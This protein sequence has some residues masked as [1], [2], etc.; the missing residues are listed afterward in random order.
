VPTHDAQRLARPDPL[1]CNIELGLR[2]VYHPIGFQL[3]LA[4]NA[5]DVI[6]AAAEC[7]AG[8]GPEFE[9][10]S[11]EFRVVVEAAG[12]VASRPSFR[13]QHQLLSIVSDAHNFAV[14]DLHSQLACIYVSQGTA[15]DH[16]LLRW[17]FLESIAY[18]LLAQR[19]AAPL[20]AASVARNEIGVLLGGAS[21]AGKS[22]LSFAAVCAG[23]TFLSDDC[24]WLLAAG[25]D[26]TAVGKP[27]QVRFRD[28]A[29]GLFP[30]LAAY[31]ARQRPNG[32]FGMEVPLSAFPELRT[33]LQCK[34]GGMA[35][36]DRRSGVQPLLERVNAVELAQQMLNSCSYGEAVDAMHEQAA[37]RLF[38]LPACRL[39]YESLDDGLR[40]LTEFAAA[41]DAGAS[42][43]GAA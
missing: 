33:A 34:I 17:C 38:G 37:S 6:D 35:L 19:Y 8:Y 22:T 25:S 10:E 1:L 27:H 32:K 16:A 26:A 31:D 43:G 7:W 23:W 12:G 18:T 2:R 14:V 36:L 13:M 4:T 24:T 29:P 40:L 39:Q 41:I 5:R 30:R 42:T 3:S 11:M 21:G 9:C 15:A 20:H 28:D